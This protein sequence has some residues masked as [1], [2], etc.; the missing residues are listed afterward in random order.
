MRSEHLTPVPLKEFRRWLFTAMDGCV[1]R[2][3]AKTPQGLIESLAIR[4][5]G[6]EH[7]EV[8]QY[9]K[10]PFVEQ[11]VVQGAKSQPVLH[12]SRSGRFV[13]PNVG[14]VKG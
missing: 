14:S 10:S 13:P 2:A 11:P 8:R 1:Q 6:D 12:L 4:H 3:S 9:G 5:I 7:P